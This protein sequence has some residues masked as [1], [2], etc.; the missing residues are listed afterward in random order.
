MP[1]E[2]ALDGEL[3]W[4]TPGGVTV[5]RPLE[6]VRKIDFSGGKI[7]YL[8]D[9]EPERSEYTPFFGTT[10]QLP[11]LARFFGPRTN[12]SLAGGPLKLYDTVY[13][14]GLA[15]HSRT[16]LTYRL[17]GRFS[18]LKAIAGIDDAFRPGGHVLLTVLG[19][20][21][22]LLTSTLTGEDDEPPFVGGARLL[23]EGSTE[24]RE[25]HTPTYP[26]NSKA[27]SLPTAVRR[28][29]TRSSL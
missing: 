12:R 25:S 29:L 1:S 13:E 8:T 26:D 22:V 11:I 27:V 6:S 28:G 9:L 23:D 18:R 7:V 4:K 15:L 20:E 5:S 2:L 17:P 24:L 19:D 3:T 14:N 10:E 16:E 21:N